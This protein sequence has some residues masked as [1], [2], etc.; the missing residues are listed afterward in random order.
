MTSIENYASDDEVRMKKHEK[1]NAEWRIEKNQFDIG[2]SS[3]STY[4]A[5]Q[6]KRLEEESDQFTTELDTLKNEIKDVERKL[7]KKKKLTKGA[8]RK[9]K[10]ILE[11]RKVYKE[12][13]SSRKAF[14]KKT[15]QRIK[16]HKITDKAV[17]KGLFSRRG[18]LLYENNTWVHDPSFECFLGLNIDLDY[19][20][21]S[22]VM[23]AEEVENIRL[24]M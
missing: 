14:E 18:W 12:K 4:W 5:E 19:V 21:M 15:K 13:K 10:Q 16:Q 7:F 6:E 3:Y 23:T 17:V 20:T 2:S 24:Q 1:E 11:K 22:D 9:V 8:E